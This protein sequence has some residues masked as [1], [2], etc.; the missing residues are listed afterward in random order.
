MAKKGEN[1][2]KRKDGR[3][4][5]RYPKERDEFNRIIKYGFVY[6][7]TYS[8]VKLKREEVLKNFEKQLN[9]S[10]V[11]KSNFNNELLLWLSYKETYLKKSTYYNYQTT[12]YSK[13]LPFF[14][15][16]KLRD[17]NREILIR[18]I[19]HLKMD[20]LSNKRVK[21]ICLIIR[22]FLKY[23]GIIIN[24]ELPKNKRSLLET[25]SKQE[26]KDIT[27]NFMN[28]NNVK[29][30][31]IVFVLYTGLRIGELCALRWSNIDLDNKL[32]Y[33]DK[34]LTRIKNDTGKYTTQVVVETPKTDN[35]IR[36]IPIHKGLLESLIKFKSNPNDYFLTSSP[37]FISTNRYYYFY[38][39]ILKKYKF[40]T[41]NF[42]IL[43]HTFA[44]NA[45]I[46]GMDIKTLSEI[47][48]HSSVKITLDRYVHIKF[49]EKA[50]QIN[51]M[52]IYRT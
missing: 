11:L 4:E 47:L 45:L 8:E 13:I 44:T 28:S 38:K 30:F 52:P 24:V 43:R 42:H 5:A 15:N 26:V 36:K 40:K 12:I 3:L 35:S 39:R 17:I 6:G 14:K 2:Y 33:I 23:K 20:K 25:L 34:T 21:D 18:F 48:G 37:N 46:N 32:I 41:Y 50:K 29:E 31:A 49:E 1:I 27:Q 22:Q 7:K 51:M 16:L 19:Q 10:K 9:K